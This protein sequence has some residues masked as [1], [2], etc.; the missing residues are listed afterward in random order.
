MT[1]QGKFLSSLVATGEHWWARPQ[2]WNTIR[3]H[4]C[5]IYKNNLF[6]PA[7]HDCNDFVSLKA[8]VSKAATSAVIVGHSSN[9]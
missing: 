5:E 9:D 7:K 8:F 6:L 3:K 2:N 4:R 1:A